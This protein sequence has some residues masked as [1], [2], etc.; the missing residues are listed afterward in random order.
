M[1]S[2]GLPAP[3]PP[4]RG[5]GGHLPCAQLAVVL[6]SSSP[7]PDDEKDALAPAAAT[8]PAADA[9]AARG[10][11]GG[12]AALREGKK[13]ARKRAKP[14]RHRL[15]PDA[16]G[17]P[18]A[19]FFRPPPGPGGRAAR[20]YA[21]G[22]ALG[23]S[24]SS[25]SA[26]GGWAGTAADDD[27]DDEESGRPYVRDRLRAGWVDRKTGASWWGHRRDPGGPKALETAK[28]RRKATQQQQQQQQQ[29]RQ[30]AGGGGG[31]W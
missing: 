24:P 6:G 17:R 7:R 11:R 28:A 15:A 21:Y 12:A 25:S 10:G 3:A 16:P 20:G 23:S 27:D 2:H 18:T 29:Q 1:R 19:H 13:K 14:K 30:Q 31:G 22:Y 26:A 9:G 4:A 8:A 5:P